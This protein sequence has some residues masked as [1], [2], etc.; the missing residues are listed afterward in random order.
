MDFIFFT[1][2]YTQ[3]ERESH[4]YTVPQQRV[5]RS[6]L[7]LGLPGVQLESYLLELRHTVVLC[8]P[9]HRRQVI[10]PVANGNTH[11]G[12]LVGSLR[13]LVECGMEPEGEGVGG[14]SDHRD[15]CGRG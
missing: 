13:T 11:L 5:V 2:R 3:K 12:P 10:D 8:R 6:G 14:Q 4:R 7:H 1:C 15:H 9:Q